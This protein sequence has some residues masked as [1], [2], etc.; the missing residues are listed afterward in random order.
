MAGA[1]EAMNISP[2][3]MPITRGEAFLAAISTLGLRSE[4]TAMAKAPLTWRRAM[5]TAS[6]SEGAPACKASSMR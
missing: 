6:P 5:R 2:W 1:S 3:P 4:I